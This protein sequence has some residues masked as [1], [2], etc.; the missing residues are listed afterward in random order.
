MR[1]HFYAMAAG[2]ATAGTLDRPGEREA[3]AG[4]P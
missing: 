2:R 1:G 4:V 3:S